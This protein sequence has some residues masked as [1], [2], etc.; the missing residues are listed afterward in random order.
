MS[1]EEHGIAVCGGKGKTSQK[2][3]SDI[4]WAGAKFGFSEETIKTLTYNSKMA[5][6]IDNTAIQAGYQLYHHAFLVTKD[7]KWAVIQQ[8]MSAEDRSARR[9]HWLSDKVTD[10]VV[11]PQNAI[12]GD[13]K[14]E[15]ALNMVA[16]DSEAARKASVDLAKEPT[17]KL[18][19]LIQVHGK[20]AQ[21]KRP[22]KIGYP[23]PAIRGGK[24]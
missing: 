6:K 3:P 17:R 14:R 4:A 22:C 15:T 18:M 9:Y 12:V 5:A 2:T 13:V 1:P 7:E 21:T 23:K 10:F 16:K 19:N 8:G 24:P 11:E 20:T